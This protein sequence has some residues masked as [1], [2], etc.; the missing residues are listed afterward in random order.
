MKNRKHSLAIIPFR[1][2]T[3][4]EKHFARMAEKGWLIESM[5]DFSWTYRRIEPQ[6][7]H[8]TAA[9]YPKASEYAPAPSEG[10]LTFR[11]FCAHTGWQYACSWQQMQVFYNDREAP[12]PIDTEPELEVQTVHAA[13]KSHYLIYNLLQLAAVLLWLAV[14]AQE[15]WQ[16]PAVNLAASGWLLILFGIV[17]L[18]LIPIG[19]LTAYFTWYWKAKK[20]AKNGI[21]VDTPSTTGYQAGLGCAWLLAFA[22]WLLEL[23]LG[24]RYDSLLLLIF[25]LVCCGGAA[26]LV[27]GI[28]RLLRRWKA[29]KSVNRV[30]STVGGAVVFL[31]LVMIIVTFAVAV[32]MERRFM[33]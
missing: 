28:P 3:G 19:E 16:H 17:C 15:F 27:R 32:F 4:L 8:F 9:C 31:A 23:A 30:V 22:L 2:R 18:A 21:L 12:V 10:E 1:D 26:A 29:P 14:S 33:P 13:F 7:L 5:S 20:A 11:E 24:G 6:R 25:L